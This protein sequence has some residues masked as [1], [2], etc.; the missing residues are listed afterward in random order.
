M[1]RIGILVIL[2]L[3]LGVGLIGCKKVKNE[4]HI[5]D[6]IDWQRLK[7]FAEYTDPYVSDNWP[8]EDEMG[9]PNCWV[10]VDMLYPQV[11]DDKYIAMRDSLVKSLVQRITMLAH[12]N[13]SKDSTQ[14]YIDSYVAAQITDYKQDLSQASE[15]DFDI[16]S[17]SLF[18]RRIDLCDSLV[19]N[20]NSIVSITML[21]QEYTGGAH[22]NDL[23]T[24]FN[25]DLER[26]EA[27]TPSALFLDPKDSRIVELLLSK[28]MTEFDVSTPEELEY[29]GI[30]N[31]QVL[32]I[33]NN[34]YFT[35]EGITFYYN[36]YELAAYAVGPIELFVTYSELSPFL[37]G[38]YTKLIPQ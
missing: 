19:Y 4:S 17:Y 18:S 20:Q 1:K 37:N 35:D 29:A 10:H 11:D 32:E 24:T 13:F 27:I 36:P 28:L 23:L 15:L 25:Y 30:F 3:S 22:G 34:F 2:F 26:N 38:A 21:S 14:A 5:N 12:N 9:I 8:K 33:T 7:A 16:Y 6:S 31:Y